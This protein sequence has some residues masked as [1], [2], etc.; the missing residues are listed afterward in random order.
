MSNQPSPR[1]GLGVGSLGK[2]QG[3]EISLWRSNRPSPGWLHLAGKT[4]A[5]LGEAWGVPVWR[6]GGSGRS[7]LVLSTQKEL[8]WLSLCI[9]VGSDRCL[10]GASWQR[11]KPALSG[12][13]GC[14]HLSRQPVRTRGETW[15]MTGDISGQ[16]S[17]LFVKKK[18][19]LPLRQIPSQVFSHCSN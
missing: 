10:G 1:G 19:L 17:Q 2:I 13:C 3:E 8:L 12:S 9:K 14:A 18:K 7:S 16:F 11:K 15:L 4:S 6:V 5:N